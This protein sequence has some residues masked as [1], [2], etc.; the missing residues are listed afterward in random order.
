MK[1]IQKQLTACLAVLL[2][3]CTVLTS[4]AN[5][6]PNGTETTGTP[7]TEEHEHPTGTTG[8]QQP[9]THATTTLVGKK[10]ATCAKEGYTGDTVCS[11]CGDVVSKGSAIPKTDH[12]YNDGVTTKNPTCIETGVLTI[13]CTG[14]GDAKTSPIPTV[15]HKDEYHDALDGSHSHT[16]STCTMNKNEQHN[17]KDDG[18][19]QNATCL[20]GAYTL[21]TCADC[22]GTYKVYSDKEEH[23][24][25]GHDWSAWQ[26]ISDATCSAT[27]K[28][29][30]TCGDCSAVENFDIP[31]DSS[32]HSFTRTNPTVTAT[33]GKSATAEY[34]CTR[35]STPKTE[36]LPA[37]GKHNYEEQENTGDGWT[38]QVCS[39]CQDEI[40]KF[41]ASNKTVAEV[42]AK[43]IP[44][45]T[46]L[47]I[48]TEKASISLPADVVSQLV[49]DTSKKVS[50]AADIVE[51]ASKDALIAGATNLK[52]EEKERLKDVDIFD[53]GITVG[54]TAVSQ[55]RAAVTVTMPYTLKEGEEPDG[56][57]IWY[58][59]D[60]GTLEEVAAVYDAETE[61]VTFSVEHFSF[62]AVAY[63]ETQAMRC[64]KGNHNY[65]QVGDPVSATCEA[66]GYT[67]YECTGCKR[68]NV[69]N[70][71][72]KTDH[73]Y[74]EL[75]QAAPTCTEGDWSFK[76]CQ[77][78]GHIL[79]V[80]FVRAKGHTPD[81]VATCT[82]PSTCTTCHTVITAAKGHSF[83]EWETIV[84]PTDVNS[85]LRRRYCL[86]C[87][88][89]EEVKLAA[90]GNIEQLKFES[91]EQLME[92]VFKKVFNLDNGTIHVD[93][94]VYGY[95]YV[96]DVTVNNSQDNFLLLVEAKEIRYTED[97]T[98]KETP[99]TMLYRN[100]VIIYEDGDSTLQTNMETL[101]EL[102]FDV[103]LNYAEQTF[104]YINPMAEAV[105]GQAKE[106]LKTYTELLG[107]QLNA[108]LAAAG[109]EYTVEDLNKILDSMET[110]YAYCAVKM[111]YHTN[112]EMQDGVRIPTQADWHTVLTALMT[113]AKNADGS[114]TYTWD[115]TE[116]LKAVD[117]LLDWVDT[118]KEKPV[119]DVLY[120]LIAAE[121][122]KS[123]P[124][125]TDWNACVAKLKASFPGTMTVKALA[126]RLFTLLEQKE[127]CTADELYA[128]INEV[129]EQNTGSEFDVES[130]LQE[131]YNKTLNEM[132]CAITG[133]EGVTME[134]MIDSFNQQLTQMTLGNVTIPVPGG[135]GVSIAQ[136]AELVESTL[137]A[138]NV[139]ADVSVT[140]DEQ[141]RLLGANLNGSILTK[142]SADEIGEEIGHLK[143]S[144]KQ[145]ETAKIT[146]PE[147]WKPLTDQTVSAV[148]DANGNLV[149]SGL[150]SE[151]DYSFTVDGEY[152]AAAKDLLTKDEEASKSFGFPVYTLPKSFWNEYTNVQRV[153]IIDG[154]YYQLENVYHSSYYTANS[155]VSLADLLSGTDKQLPD[156]STVPAGK[157]WISKREEY[158]PVYETVFG[159]MW[160]NDG[161]WMCSDSYYSYNSSGDGEGTFVQ[162]S[163][164]EQEEYQSYANLL[165]YSMESSSYYKVKIDGV[166]RELHRIR[167]ADV[168]EPDQ[169]VLSVYGYSDNGSIKIVNRHYNPS[170]DGYKLG[171]QVTQLDAH[172]SSD[173][174]EST[175]TLFDENGN[176]E[177]VTVTMLST[178]KLLPTFY[179][180][181]D[182][183]S[184]A[185]AGY[186]TALTDDQLSE[187]EQIKLSD[188][189]VL[190]RLP[191]TVSGGIAGY[192]KTESGKYVQTIVTTDESGA[193]T[194]KVTYRGG[195]R[196]MLCVEFEDMFDTAQYITKNTD[197]TFTISAQ[198]IKLL[199][200][201]CI[202]E[203][204]GYSLQLIG[205]LTKNGKDYLVQQTLMSY[206]KPETLAFGS[207]HSESAWFNWDSIFGT[208]GVSDRYAVT[209]NK[210]GSLTITMNDGSKITEVEY[211]ANGGTIA[212]D[213]F[214]VYNEDMSQQAGADI[215]GNLFRLSDTYETV[216]LLNG[217]YYE[218]SLFDEWTAVEKKNMDE[219]FDEIWSINRMSLR[220]WLTIDEQ[221]L[222]VYEVQIA[223]T[224]LD[225]SSHFTCFAT[226]QN[227]QLY[228]LKQAKELGN[229][230]LQYEAIVPISEYFAS[231][232]LVVETTRYFDGKAVINGE[233]GKLYRMMCHLYETDANGEAIKDEYGDLISLSNFSLVVFVDDKTEQTH[234]IGNATY[235]GSHVQVEEE[236]VP[237]AIVNSTSTWENTY[238]NGKYTFVDLT[239]VNYEYVAYIRINGQLYNYEQYQSNSY[240]KDNFL[241]FYGDQQWVYAL[242]DADKEFD[243]N[244]EWIACDYDGN[245]IEKPTDWMNVSY[246]LLYTDDETGKKLYEVSGYT[247]KTTK[248]EDGT[249]LYGQSGN[250]YMQGP[251]GNF[252]AVSI[253]TD[254][255]GVEQVVCQLQDSTI[256]GYELSSMHLLDKYITITNDGKLIISAD[257]KELLKSVNN[258]WMNIYTSEG[259]NH[260]VGGLK[261]Y[262]AS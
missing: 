177:R 34:I 104:E 187:Y 45:D 21:M 181:V 174:Y 37:T 106:M 221:Q 192:I 33:C 58:V 105:L 3:L 172:D 193:L 152:H 12:T 48:T 248:R 130:V 219:V 55:F 226:V 57:L 244:G 38:R 85:G 165:L 133:A 145:D 25:T 217:K 227:G 148:F 131:Y 161:K 166:E 91:Y 30:R 154:K 170:V 213:S 27:G 249:I 115:V 250:L 146:L 54:E 180:K 159:I 69:D 236:Y 49:E 237:T 136:L 183:N 92:A 110:V 256:D 228:I 76:E 90:S 77:D 63:K 117:T 112:L 195:L 96:I 260:Y 114:T 186:L 262:F 127:I 200:E 56:I 258:F 201:K 235:V 167:L 222:P 74:G 116:L 135:E 10:D 113:P 150:S 194:S 75:Q 89:V 119:S 124:E 101:T 52:E 99:F 43:D 139:T 149:V 144:V 71:V 44:T 233:A 31:V 62:Y 241:Y 111:G 60:D 254:D 231:L 169:T 247:L 73:S 1:R 68:R 26:T 155:T 259:D 216:V 163:V 141:G 173:I 168:N 191:K 36:N 19:F 80:E 175:I 122:T 86:S 242:V 4:C 61:T 203:G 82:T 125:L 239:F 16:C 7:G 78:C 53:F 100:G 24:A 215:Y 66:H 134:D 184:F 29:T 65:V 81:G 98:K 245:E 137:S 251:D 129:V 214:L 120:G 253:K 41:D 138:L 51:Q 39:V 84:V 8:A 198:L 97:G 123:Y 72:E 207:S 208:D 246:Y 188:G 178:Y 224:Q 2:V 255:N 64:K 14:C 209:L 257:A 107:T 223:L 232:K 103:L 240:S 157:M 143:F 204:D 126:D 70:F 142:G 243:F 9:C 15:A 50:V 252:I 17:P 87:G 182:A 158:V 42:E 171:K 94:A 185:E 225:S 6:K 13:T 79:N 151:L 121:L 202:S 35:C 22:G 153:V 179:A 102:P 132:V 47:A 212:L 40:A 190:Y 218:Y 11:A 128:I 205:E 109:T 164:Y 230:M 28:K 46:T 229:S 220:Y 234:F 83:T 18:V 59:A 32:A 93:A 196:D 156:E 95:N 23:K 147:A 160:Q 108:V 67:V 88:K 5:T 162:F 118:N 189:R 176:T 261:D 199:G 210:D 197:G 238:L 140:L 206:L 211:Q 20:E